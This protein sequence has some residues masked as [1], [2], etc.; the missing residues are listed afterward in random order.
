[1]LIKAIMIQECY[2]FVLKVK[3]KS[4]KFKGRPLL[5]LTETEVRIRK[6]LEYLNVP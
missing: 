5:K 4:I 1:M 6:T 2:R 3:T